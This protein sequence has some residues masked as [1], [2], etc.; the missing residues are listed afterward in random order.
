MEPLYICLNIQQDLWEVQTKLQAPVLMNSK[1]EKESTII[2]Y[3][4]QKF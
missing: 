4:N 1:I 3:L 2:Y